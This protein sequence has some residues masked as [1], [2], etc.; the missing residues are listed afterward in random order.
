[1]LKFEHHQCIQI[2]NEK[3]FDRIFKYTRAGLKGMTLDTW[4][5]KY[6]YPKFPIYLEHAISVHG[7]SI[8][9]S[10]QPVNTWTNKPMEVLSLD[11]ALFE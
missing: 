3:E 7:S 9:Y 11:Q 4:S 6:G 10:D 8:G 1:M 2:N 5:S